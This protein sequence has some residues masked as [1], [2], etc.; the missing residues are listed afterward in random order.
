MYIVTYLHT[1][2][3]S[4]PGS[5]C[6]IEKLGMGPGNEADTYHFQFLIPTFAA[7]PFAWWG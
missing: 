6:N 3:A 2:L 7:L 5:P 1:Y 4:S